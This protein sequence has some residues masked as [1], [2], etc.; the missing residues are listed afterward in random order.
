M[1]IDTAFVIGDSHLVCEDYPTSYQKDDKCGVILCDGCSSSEMVDV[2]ARLLALTTKDVLSNYPSFSLKQNIITGLQNI[3]SLSMFKDLPQT[4]FDATLMIAQVYK[5]N[6]IFTVFGDGVIAL[7]KKNDDNIAI[8][9]V[10]C[11][12][13]YPRYLSYKLD[14]DREINYIL[15]TSP[16]ID[17]TRTNKYLLKKD[18]DKIQWYAEYFEEFY[19]IKDMEWIA[20]MSDGVH[21]FQD[22][23][24]KEI[25]YTSIVKILTDFKTTAGDFVKRRLNRFTKE[26]KNLQWTHYDD[27]SLAA[28]YFD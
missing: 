11:P 13:G 6:C 5:E 23:N 26:C 20:L 18:V 9:N 14:T 24:K 22:E 28:I 27:V 3:K 1:N 10:S 19:L 25:D 4:M 8:I 7:K 16:V 17:V 21:S 2:G 15:N 12:T